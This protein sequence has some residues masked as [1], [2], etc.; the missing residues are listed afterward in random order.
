MKKT[1]ATSLALGVALTSSSA[2][3]ENLGQII[4]LLANQNAASSKSQASVTKLDGERSELER[5]YDA[6]A[7]QADSLKIYVDQLA[8]SVARQR[9]QIAS[10]E[11]QIERVTDV[12]RRTVPLIERMAANLESFVKVDVP[13]LL[14]ERQERVKRVRETLDRADVTDAEKYRIVL[15]AY[16]IENE[17]GR[18]I[19]A[20][21]GRL[22]SADGSEDGR[23]VNFL[24][25]GR[26]VFAYATLDG[27]EFGV[28]NQA[29]RTW[30]DLP[31]S[32]G[33]GILRGLRIARKQ[34]AP[35]LVFLPVAAPT[36]A[37]AE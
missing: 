14:Q 8:G 3:A 6:T 2:L 33:P 1:L 29:T 24:R 27:K 25:F 31:E 12:G 16:Q 5:E 35:D 19:E 4:K 20:Y 18:T 11:D 22:P 7:R 10:L 36:D 9:E 26:V 23:V 13:F 15:E 17:Y 21:E 30:E 34:A 32:F 37:S 28:W